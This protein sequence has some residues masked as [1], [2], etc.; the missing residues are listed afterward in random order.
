MNV[1]NMIFDNVKA[2]METEYKNS[3]TCQKR[4]STS[5]FLLITD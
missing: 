5:G 1:M 3:P 2:Y 4:I